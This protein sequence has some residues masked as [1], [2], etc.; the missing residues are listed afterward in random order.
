MLVDKQSE[1]LSDLLFTVHQHGGDDVTWKPP[2]K[3]LLVVYFCFSLLIEPFVLWF[4]F[5][6]VASRFQSASLHASTN[7]VSPSNSDAVSMLSCFTAA[8]N[9]DWTV[10]DLRLEN[11]EK[12]K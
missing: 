8:S 5:N 12:Q 10:C 7:K 2:N 11:G 1:L 4:A 3:G 9:L 6:F